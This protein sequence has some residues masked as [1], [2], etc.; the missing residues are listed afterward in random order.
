MWSYNILLM[1]N[2][3]YNMCLYMLTKN[4]YIILHLLSVVCGLHKTVYFKIY[5]MCRYN[6]YIS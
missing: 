1:R 4:M 3:I 2:D 6:V 5:S